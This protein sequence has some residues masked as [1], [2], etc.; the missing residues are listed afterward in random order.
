MSLQ[1]QNLLVQQQQVTLMMV[2]FRQ[3][4]PLLGQIKMVQ[5]SVLRTDEN[6]NT[7]DELTCTSTVVDNDEGTAA[8]VVL[9]APV[10]GS[11]SIDPETQSIDGDDVTV[12]YT[13]TIDGVGQPPRPRTGAKYVIWTLYRWCYHWMW[14]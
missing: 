9:V 14:C 3:T 12:S 13:W 11:V 4:L 10:I 7:G 5:N 2:I 6:S 1:E 8:M